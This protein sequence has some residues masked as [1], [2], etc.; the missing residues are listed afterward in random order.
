MKIFHPSMVAPMVA[1]SLSVATI[2][3]VTAAPTQLDNFDITSQSKISS[4]KADSQKA[5]AAKPTSSGMISH[6]DNKLGK[7]TFV[8]QGTDQAKPDM[9]LIAA[10]NKNEYAASYYLSALTGIS[11]NKTNAVKA[12]LSNMHDVQRGAIVAKYK[13]E[14]HGVEVFNREYNVM[15]DREHNLVAGS[16]YLSDTQINGQ[17][18]FAAL[19]NFSNSESALR[20]AFKDMAGIDV[21][22]SQTKQSGG[23]THFAADSLDNGKVVANTT[24]SKK[25]FFE[26]NGKLTA[27]YYTK[28][29]WTAITSVMLYRLT[30]VRSCSVRICIH[31][32]Q[33]LTTASSLNKTVIL[34][35]ALMET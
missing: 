12:V 19:A 10:E 9:E 22:L 11:T 15:M 16:G 29:A 23:Y 5:L 14:V 3:A 28:A 7:A 32:Q 17:N 35:K 31:M 30:A 13:Q 8:W 2:G 34:L 18:S 21:N 25:V 20:A 1:S 33:T 26:V 4:L 6:Y 24:R 27:A